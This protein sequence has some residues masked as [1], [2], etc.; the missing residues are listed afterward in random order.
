MTTELSKEEA[1]QGTTGNG[2][3]Y[4]LVASVAL[5]VVALA[6]AAWFVIG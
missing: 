6:L 5:A 3:R 1:R 4:V 2:V